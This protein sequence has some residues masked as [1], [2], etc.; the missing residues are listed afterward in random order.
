[1][2]SKLGKTLNY[3]MSPNMAIL[4]SVSIHFIMSSPLSS[5]RL[6]QWFPTVLH[7]RPLF[8]ESES[9][10]THLTA[11]PYI[12][13]SQLIDLNFILCFPKSLL[14]KDRHTYKLKLTWEILKWSSFKIIF[15]LKERAEWNQCFYFE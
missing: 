15:I 10:A 5:M 8:K 14:D 4:F 11:A 3:E 2:F 7:S 6:S 12:S 13:Y 1:M 9:F